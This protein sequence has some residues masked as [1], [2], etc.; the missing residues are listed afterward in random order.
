MQDGTGNVQ[1]YGAVATTIKSSK[2]P[3]VF[4]AGYYCDFALLAKA[5]R[6]AGYTGTLMSDDGSLDPHYISEAGAKVADG[7]YI[8]CACTNLTPKNAGTFMTAFKKLAGFPVGT[9]SGEAYDATNA[10]IKVMVSLGVKHI[11]RANI[12]K[13]LSTVT[14][15][16]FTKTVH[17]KSDGDIVG[18]AVYIYHVVN[19]K[20]VEIDWRPRLLD[21]PK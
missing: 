17:F 9:Y 14:Y 10:I 21:R 16:G 1:Q 12:V 5:L 13:G 15:K 6:A 19:G 4:Y 11:T 2:A 18:T 8:S 3:V 7:T 20:I